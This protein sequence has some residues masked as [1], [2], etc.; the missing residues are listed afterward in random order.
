ML[1]Q[2]PGP[3]LNPAQLPTFLIWGAI[4]AI[5]I[6]LLYKQ[7]L[8]RKISIILLVATLVTTGLLIGGIPNPLMPLQQIFVN[9]G[10]G[11]PISSILPMIIITVALIVSTFFVGRVF[12]GHACFLGAIQELASKLTFNSKVKKDWKHILHIES[13]RIVKLVRFVFLVFFVIS[14]LISGLA[15][16]QLF[17]PFSGFQIFT[18]PIVPA[19]LIPAIWLVG[20]FVA[21]FFIYRPWCRF[22][23]P[24]G[25]IA[26][27]TSKFSRYKLRRTDACTECG[28]CEKVCPTGEAYKDSTK[29]ECYL[30]NRCI[31]VCPVNA[32][33]P[34]KE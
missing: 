16:T 28:L 5:S 25:A 1:L 26:S 24:F 12:C 34:G 32:I 6:F 20:I 30:C 22:L 27:F 4:I 13:N 3:Q 14:A 18:K 7:K 8:T 2:T 21:S 19:V 29:E 23:C 15:F 31:D 17:N 10:L 9:I 33:K 11:R